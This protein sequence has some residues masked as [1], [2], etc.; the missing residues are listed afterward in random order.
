MPIYEFYCAHCNTIFNFLSRR[1]ETARIP[2]C[3]R[4]RR[5]LKKQMSI[6]AVTGR[7]KEEDADNPFPDLDESKMERV[8]GE[9]AAEAENMNE[10][11]PRQMAALMRKFQARTGLDLGDGMEEALA[12]LEAGEDPDRLEEEMGDLFGDDADPMAMLQKA[13]KRG[14]RP[15]P[16]RDETLYEM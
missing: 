12:R 14:G 16:A 1:I 8:L 4:C 5:S 9:L 2:D 6:F 13:R 10:D 3:P 15:E 7:A 11:D